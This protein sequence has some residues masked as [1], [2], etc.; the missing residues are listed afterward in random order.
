MRPDA[1]QTAAYATVALAELLFV[2]SCRAELRPARGL[3]RNHHLEAA[4]LGSLAFL[5]ATIYVPAL[6]DSFGT[7]SLPL[8][9]LGIVLAL[10]LLPVL[11]SES[12]KAVVRRVRR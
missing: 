10:A 4:V 3:P 2:F 12:L 5:L 9:E 8:E 7:V 11:A 6:R 1:A